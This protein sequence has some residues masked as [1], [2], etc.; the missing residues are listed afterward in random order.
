MGVAEAPREGLW[1]TIS[2]FAWLIRAP[3]G[4]ERASPAGWADGLRRKQ[5]NG[6][7]S[8]PSS[9]D[10]AGLASSLARQLGELAGQPA[11]T[12]IVGLASMLMSRQVLCNQSSRRM[13][14]TREGSGRVARA[15][16][17]L[18][19]PAR[20]V[21]GMDCGRDESKR[22]R[23]SRPSIPGRPDAPRSLLSWRLCCRGG[24]VFSAA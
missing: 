6:L 23:E 9:A 1:D 15:W 18:A 8:L 13:Q 2:K 5:P 14:P 12:K 10:G 16:A 3:N 22:A 20:G 17:C 24:A 7:A 19:C 4:C 21:T 11:R